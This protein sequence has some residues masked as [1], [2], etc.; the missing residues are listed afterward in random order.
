[1]NSKIIQYKEEPFTQYLRYKHTDGKYYVNCLATREINGIK[2]VC[3]Y[4]HKREDR[5]KANMLQQN[6]HFHEWEPE[7]KRTKT[8]LDYYK[9]LEKD[10]TSKIDFSEE[11][12]R[13]RLAILLGKRNIS[14]DTGASD[15]FYDFIIYCISYGASIH[16]EKDCVEAAKSAYHHFKQDALRVSM[17]QAAK[18]L[19]MLMIEE[20]KNFDFCS[21]AIDEGAT[22]GEK[23]VAF[24]LENPSS[25]LDPYTI[26]LLPIEDQTARGYVGVLLDGLEA[27]KRFGI[28]VAS[29]ICDGNTAQK[30][31]FK[32]SWAR[33]LRNLKDYPWLRSILYIPCLCHRI[34]NAYK[35]IISH[36]QELKEIIINAREIAT[37]CKEHKAELG[38]VCPTFIKTR[39]LYDFDIITFL[40]THKEKIEQFISLPPELEEILPN[41]QI[42][43]TLVQIFE[44]PKT[45]FCRAFHYLERAQ[46]NYRQLIEEENSYAT[47][48]L[49]SLMK[50]TL[51]S[52]DSGIWILGYIF[53]VQGHDDFNKRIFGKVSNDIPPLEIKKSNIKLNLAEDPLEQTVEEF[54]EE[55]FEKENESNQKRSE[56]ERDET[57]DDEKSDTYDFEKSDTVDSEQNDVDDLEKS[58]TSDSEQ[59]DVDDLEKSDTV[60]SRKHQYSSS[61]DDENGEDFQNPDRFKSYMQY[62]REWL[63]QHF[64]DLKWETSQISQFIASFNQFVEEKN[65]FE[66][67]MNC[68]DCGYS[69]VQIEKDFNSFTPLAN[70]ARR[71]QA[72]GVSEA[73]C[74]RTISQQRLIFAARRR[75]SNRDLLEARLTIMNAQLNPQKIRSQKEERGKASLLKRTQPK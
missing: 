9:P 19:D 7:T 67:Y 10:D 18:Q 14:L 21:V 49:E 50:Y 61:D 22:F 55:F 42:L 27:I 16:V 8:L 38:A 71:L 48:F 35:S 32:Y 57:E 33:S 72:S 54:T 41:L 68:S 6:W 37:Q 4:K 24:N 25:G 45:P 51:W 65:P 59:S 47:L 69:W 53:S 40:L 63:R 74:E 2:Y 23:N 31:A 34:S 58:D 12:L 39:W 3:K 46:V 43:K 15:E 44:D 1:M 56:A 64:L 29:C 26:R 73:S 75:A 13:Q 30:K 52:G 20:F 36:N 5:H 62:A 70:L 66:D 60:D 11:G 17:I 28:N